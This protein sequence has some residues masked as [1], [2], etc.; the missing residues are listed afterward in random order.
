MFIYN[1]CDGYFYSWINE[2]EA[3]YSVQQMNS[4]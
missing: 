3:K 2:W 1:C 4:I